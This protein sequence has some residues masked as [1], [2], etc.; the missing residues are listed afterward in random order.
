M[1]KLFYPA[2]FHTAEEG[3]FWITFPDFP[4]CLTQ[5]GN[6]QEAYEMAVDALGRSWHTSLF[7]NLISVFNVYTKLETVSF[8]NSLAYTIPLISNI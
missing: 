1:D 7:T 6:M 3:G 8:L 4:E 2:V 5:G